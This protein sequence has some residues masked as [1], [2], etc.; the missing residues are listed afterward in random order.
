M[1]AEAACATAGAS[2]RRPRL[3]RAVT[4][5][6]TAT[7]LFAGP[8]AQ[9]LSAAADV[10]LTGQLE[11]ALV[12]CAERFYR[13]RRDGEWAPQFLGQRLESR[14]GVGRVADGGVREPPLRAQAS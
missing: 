7:I 5:R 4:A 10:A 3:A 13:R 8:H 11:P 2:N 12:W 9:R 14:G 1:P 6:V